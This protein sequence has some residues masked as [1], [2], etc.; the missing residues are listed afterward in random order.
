M[1]LINY[2]HKYES[3]GKF[4]FTPTDECARKGE[5][6]LQFFRSYQFPPYFFHYASGGHVAALHTHLVNKLFFKIDLKNFFYSISR[7]RVAAALYHFGFPRARTYAK[8]STVISPY[9]CGPRYVLPIGFVQSPLLS[10]LVLA[11]SLVSQAIERAQ[12]RGCW[13]S[14]YF[15]D[16][17]GSGV[18]EADLTATY[19]DVL[20]TFAEA[21]LTP[22][23]QK[24]LPPAAA[25][26]A[27]NCDLAHGLAEVTAKRI[28]EFF[29]EP[30]SPASAKGFRDYEARVASQNFP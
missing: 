3:R 9:N 15:D 21:K 30:R 11:R 22:N 26:Q 17:I 4:I 25:I 23:P 19:N 29:S 2:E 18:D 1:Q 6:L 14:I 27:F 8:W 5:Y 20:A 16:F 28:A 13:V 10:S 7:N 12:G 24:L